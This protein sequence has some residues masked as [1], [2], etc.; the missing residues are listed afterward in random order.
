VDLFDTAYAALATQAGYALTFPIH[1][2][3]GLACTP[4]GSGQEGT[5]KRALDSEPEQ[6]DP[7][8]EVGRPMPTM[9]SDDTKINL[10]A[11]GYRRDAG[12]LLEG[13]TCFT[14]RKHSRAYVHHLL[15]S[16]EM[17]AHVL[18]ELHNTHHTLRF[19]QAIRDAIRHGTLP[20]LRQRLSGLKPDRD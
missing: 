17:L 4:S 16:H 3:E 7:G 1:K 20:S 10:W 13:C 2:Q 15:M 6:A 5:R 9:G 14:C 8:G 11:E 12:P 19:F 18:L